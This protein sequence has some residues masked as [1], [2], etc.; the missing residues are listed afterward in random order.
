MNL[1]RILRFAAVGAVNTGVYYGC[2]LALRLVLP[3]LVAHVVAFL[4]AMV[5]SYFLNCYVTFHIRPH[6]RSFALFPLSNAANFTITTVGMRL[7]VGWLG[8][9]ERIAPVP[10]ALVAIPITYVVA[11]HIMLGRLTDPY[12]EEVERE[13]TDTAQR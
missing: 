5:G 8:V 1:S 2:Y 6:W 4:V 12:R 9:D 3:Y 10:V 7:M 13:A 11:H